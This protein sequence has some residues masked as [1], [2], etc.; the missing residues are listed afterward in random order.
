MPVLISLLRGVNVGGNRKIKMDALKELY[1]D[2]GMREVQTY[3]QSGNVV[4]RCTKRAMPAL[5]VEIEQAI[6]VKFGFRPHVVLR[7]LEE[8]RAVVA[9]S[10]FAARSGVDPNKLHVHFLRGNAGAHAHTLL[11]KLPRKQEEEMHLLGRE[12]F[13]YYPEGIGQSKITPASFDKAL[14][15]SSTA[16]N[17]NTVTKLLAMAEALASVQ[18]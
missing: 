14:E 13:V 15:T 16:R 12:V 11:E 5:A 18:R 8:L 10:P 1:A 3:I 4:C 2:L 7:T 17:W 6:E 9:A